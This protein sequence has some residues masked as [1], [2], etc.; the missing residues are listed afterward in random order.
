[1]V[2]TLKSGNYTLLNKDP[3]GSFERKVASTLRKHKQYFS[4]EKR[5]RLTPHHSKIPHMYGLP[6]IHKPDVPLRPIISSRDSPCRELS[7]VLLDIIKPLAGQTDSFIKNS[8][9]FVEKSKQ[10]KLTETDKL[11]SFDVESL[12]TKVPV[13][14]TL[15]I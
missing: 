8:K 1:M 11:V 14:E 6:K 10:I 12:F 3:T 5:T 2:E 7:K 15:E 4:E 13:P 9:D